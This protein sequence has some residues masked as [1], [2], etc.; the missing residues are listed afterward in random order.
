MVVNICWWGT[1]FSATF[2]P[3]FTFSN[4]AMTA[5]NPASSAS[6]PQ[7]VKARVSLPAAAPESCSAP[8][9]EQ[10]L[11]GEWLDR[12]ARGGQRRA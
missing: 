8:A 3:G 1:A 10:T 2:E 6:V 12:V 7:V 11:L 4:A 5:R 9:A